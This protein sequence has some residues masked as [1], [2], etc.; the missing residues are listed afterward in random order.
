MGQIT[1]GFV[2]GTE[3]GYVCGVIIVIGHGICSPFLFSMAY[4]MYV[5]TKSRLLLNNTRSYTFLN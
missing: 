4:C 3:V 2:R 5:G 1:V